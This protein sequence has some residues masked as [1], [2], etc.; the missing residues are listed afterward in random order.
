MSDKWYVSGGFESFPNG[1]DPR[2]AAIVGGN[3]VA[4]KNAFQFP[5]SAEY[6]MLS[7]RKKIKLDVFV[8][9]GM[10][11]GVQFYANPSA[12]I[13]NPDS[14]YF[15]F[16][17]PIYYEEIE[18]TTLRKKVFIAAAASLH[19]NL[20]FNKSVFLIGYINQ[21]MALSKKPFIQREVKYKMSASQPEYYSATAFSTGTVFQPG[22]GLGVRF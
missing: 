16:N 12:T 18:A 15:V 2:P 17:N 11:L 19:V 14:S 13:A 22:F 20:H 9:A 8:K 21:Q 4:I 1:V 3:G 10:V 7:I 5:I 6:K